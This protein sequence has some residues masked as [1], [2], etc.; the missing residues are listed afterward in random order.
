MN[1]IFFITRSAKQINSEFVGYASIACAQILSIR[2]LHTRMTHNRLCVNAVHKETASPNMHDY[3]C[4][5][6]AKDT[7][8]PAIHNH[9][10]IN[11]ANKDT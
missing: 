11:A 2:T 1:I 8:P 9:L 4:I 5:N 10:C 3:L 7:A 6:A